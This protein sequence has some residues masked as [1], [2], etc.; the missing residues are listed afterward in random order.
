MVVVVVFIIIIIIIIIIVVNIVIV[1]DIAII[2]I[3]VVVVIFIII[4]SKIIIVVIVVIIIFIYITGVR[5]VIYGVDFFTSRCLIRLPSLLT[6]TDL[7]SLK[8][9]KKTLYLNLLS[10]ISQISLFLSMCV[11]NYNNKLNSKGKRDSAFANI[12]DG[13]AFLIWHES[14]TIGNL[15]QQVC[16]KLK[17]RV[18]V[19]RDNT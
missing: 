19:N 13:Q 11:I 18:Q 14:D 8:N 3:V 17:I 2:I 7:K 6:F 4:V 16:F 9:V 12:Q 15:I 10:K 5:S 1:V